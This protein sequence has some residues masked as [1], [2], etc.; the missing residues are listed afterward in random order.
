M[1]FISSASRVAVGALL[2]TV[3]PL[4]SVANGEPVGEPVGVPEPIA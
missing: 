1:S 4:G 3:A 2:V